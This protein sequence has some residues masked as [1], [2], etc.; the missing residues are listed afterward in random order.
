MATKYAITGGGNWSGATWNTASNQA[1]SNT[2]KPVAGD[3]AV[4]DQYSGSVTIDEASAANTLT[5]TGYANTFTVNYALVLNG[6]TSHVFAGT[7]TGNGTTAYGG[8][9]I[10]ITTAT[11]TVNAVNATVDGTVWLTGFNTLNYSGGANTKWVAYSMSAGNLVL[12]SNFYTINFGT[13]AS[14]GG[15]YYIYVYGSVTGTSYSGNLGTPTIRMCGTGSIPLQTLG[16]NWR[17]DT[18]GTITWAA[19]QYNWSNSGKTFTYVKGTQVG[20]ADVSI[21]VN[22]ATTFDTNGMTWGTVRLGSYTLTLSS[23]LQATTFDVTIGVSGAATG[24]N[25]T[26]DTFLLENKSVFT[27]Q[28]TKT[29]TCNHLYFNGVQGIATQLVSSSAGTAFNI[30]YNGTEDGYSIF[31]TTLKDVNF[32]NPRKMYSWFGT[33]TSGVTNCTVK[34]PSD[35]RL[36]MPQL[37]GM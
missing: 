11:V 7:W 2:T 30:V 21:G 18:L 1:S 6:G 22:T 35:A 16:C 4:L 17:I 27:M 32:T 29:I 37:V 31:L 23:D 8:G 34:T 26:C 36:V 20:L 14:I 25:I 12:S 10:S 15:S 19:G 9:G 24:G 28:A 5:M 3:I 13:Q 33:N